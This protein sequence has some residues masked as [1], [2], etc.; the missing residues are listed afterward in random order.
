[1]KS[2]RISKKGFF[3]KYSLKDLNEIAHKEGDYFCYCRIRGYRKWLGRKLLGKNDVKTDQ[4]D[5]ERK[6]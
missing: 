2:L 1:M 6:A 4:I 5:N 3:K